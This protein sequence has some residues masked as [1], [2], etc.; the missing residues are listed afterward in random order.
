MPRRYAAVDF[1]QKNA[2]GNEA[3]LFI[4]VLLTACALWQMGVWLDNGSGQVSVLLILTTLLYGAI[5]W[6]ARSG[7][8]LGVAM[9]SLG[10]AFGAETGYISVR[11]VPIGS[12]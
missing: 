12:A 10:N 5:G 9:L 7:L 3:A 4:A 6:F 8:V 1:I 2:Y 11:G